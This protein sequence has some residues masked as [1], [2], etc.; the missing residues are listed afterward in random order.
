MFP[1]ETFHY[2]I[3][4]LTYSIKK[5]TDLSLDGLVL[6]VLASP[7]PPPLPAGP[8]FQGEDPSELGRVLRDV[9][10]RGEAH[11]PRDRLVP[12]S[13]LGLRLLYLARLI[14]GPQVA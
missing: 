1:S 9:D 11:R 2:A 12:E 8:G 10:Q 14:S 5:L 6:V 7:P 13:N 4:Q 3:Q